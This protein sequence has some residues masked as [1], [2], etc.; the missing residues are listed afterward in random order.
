MPRLEERIDA[1]E[2]RDAPPARWHRA[3]A[4]VG[5]P[6]EAIRT[7]MGIPDGDNIIVRR[8]VDVAAR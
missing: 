6:V 5:E 1:L 2:S 3:V 8:I 4:K 7:R